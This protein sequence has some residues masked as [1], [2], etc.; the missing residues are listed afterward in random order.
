MAISNSLGAA[1]HQPGRLAIRSRWLGPAIAALAILGVGC[2]QPSEPFTRVSVEGSVTLDDQPLDEA[3]IRFIP[4]GS[5]AGPMTMF[6]IREG[7]FTASASD[8]PPVG[9]HRVEIN[10]AAEEE[11]AHDDEQALQRLAQSPRRTISR[12]RLPDVYHLRSRLTATLE[13]TDNGAAQTLS[14]PLSS[15]PR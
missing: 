8:G 2:E 11:F 14:F 12:P 6:P 9:T 1:A 7:R 13:D 4:T 5:T 10:L 15:R 3:T